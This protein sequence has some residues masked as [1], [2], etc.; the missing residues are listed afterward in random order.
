MVNAAASANDDNDQGDVSVST[1]GLSWY[2]CILRINSHTNSDIKNGKYCISIP[3]EVRYVS[4]SSSPY[5]YVTVCVC[6]RMLNAMNKSV[7][8]YKR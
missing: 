4:N 3:L 6:M 7:L 5:V 2:A 8:I 1:K